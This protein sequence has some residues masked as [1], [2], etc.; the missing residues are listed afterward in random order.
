MHQL[1]VGRWNH[2]L[3][4]ASHSGTAVFEFHTVPVVGRHRHGTVL[5]AEWH[6][7][8]RQGKVRGEHD[9]LGSHAGYR[10]A[11]G[12]SRLTFLEVHA[13]GLV[14]HAC[15][16]G[17]A[18]LG[19]LVQ[20]TSLLRLD[21]VVHLEVFAAPELFTSGRLLA[22]LARGELFESSVQAIR[23]QP[24][25]HLAGGSC[26]AVLI[27][28]GL[29][30][31]VEVLGRSWLVGLLGRLALGLG[32]DG[33]EKLLGHLGFDGLGELLGH[34]GLGLGLLVVYDVDESLLAG[35]GLGGLLGRLALGLG[36]DEVLGRLALGVG[37]SGLL[38]RLALGLG[39]HARGEF[40]AG[41]ALGDLPEL[42]ELFG[43]VRDGVQ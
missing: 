9:R 42:L 8:I 43:A 25:L 6:W 14:S 17:T 1:G 38:G 34:L 7:E 28:L 19:R 22:R 31:R 4:D 40:V 24:F 26:L 41:R 5:E 32:L 2:T 36:L 18:R 33:L 30:A 16:P 39:L 27:V 15:L 20:A 37:L 10:C 21:R 11:C 12:L 35:L 3:K 13:S 29:L 23:T